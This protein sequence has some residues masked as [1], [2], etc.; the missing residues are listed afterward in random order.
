MEPQGTYQ[1]G[2][3]TADDDATP[4]K[5]IP[6]R[7][8]T[9]VYND[10]YDA[11]IGVVSPSAYYVLQ[12]LIRQTLGFHRDGTRSS[13]S[14]IAEATNLSRHT[15]ITALRELQDMHIVTSD[16]DTLTRTQIRTYQ[17]QPADSWNLPPKTSAKIALVEK[18]K[19]TS[20]KIALDTAQTSA[21]NA[22]DGAS[23][24]AK[25]ALIKSKLEKKENKR[26]ENTDDANAS[27]DA[28]ARSATPRKSP[29]KKQPKQETPEEKE[30]RVA[31]AVY[32]TDLC[33]QQ[34]AYLHCAKSPKAG[35]DRAG[36]H[37]FYTAGPDGASADAEQVMALYQVVKRTPF[38]QGKFLTLQAITDY[39]PT[40]QNNP[41]DV[42]QAVADEQRKAEYARAAANGHKPK[43]PT[44]R[45]QTYTKTGEDMAP[46]GWN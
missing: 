27:A 26:K 31:E 44:D 15:V 35:Q 43:R 18:R 45:Q 3:A 16:G 25:I 36:G 20:A 39:W 6:L 29:P 37:W 22:L 33:K 8:W 1:A 34:L 42:K 17:M 7:T 11:L 28:Q 9:R 41:A 24:S 21:D 13:L 4:E 2:N 46:Q 14:V 38:W 12:Y 19:R 23:T 32:V 5:V 40:W 10:Y 30:A